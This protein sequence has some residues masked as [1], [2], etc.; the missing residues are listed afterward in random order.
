MLLKRLLCALA[1]TQEEAAGG[2]CPS[3]ARHRPHPVALAPFVRVSGRQ[4]MDC[5]P[6]LC[7][8]RPGRMQNAGV[9]LPGHILRLGYY[10]YTAEKAIRAAQ[11]L[12]RVLNV[13]TAVTRLV[14]APGKEVSRQPSVQSPRASNPLEDAAALKIQGTGL[15]VVQ[16]CARWRWAVRTCAATA[17]S[18]KEGGRWRM[19]GSEG[20]RGAVRASP[21]PHSGPVPCFREFQ[22]E[23]REERAAAEAERD[24]YVVR[25]AAGGRRAEGRMAVTLKNGWQPVDMRLRFGAV[26]SELRRAPER[27][28]LQTHGSTVGI[29]CDCWMAVPPPPPPHT[30]DMVVACPCPRARTVVCCV[31]R[32]ASW[33]DITLSLA[34]D[35]LETIEG[36]GAPDPACRPVRCSLQH[37]T[38]V[39]S[40]PVPQSLGCATP[41]PIASSA[42]PFP[43]PRKTGCQPMAVVVRNTWANPGK[44]GGRSPQAHRPGAWRLPL[45]RSKGRG[46]HVRTFSEKHHRRTVSTLRG[47]AHGR[48]GAGRAFQLDHRRMRVG[49]VPQVPGPWPRVSPLPPWRCPG[50]G[51]CD[52]QSCQ[53]SL[54]GGS[55]FAAADYTGA[56]KPKPPGAVDESTADPLEPA[57]SPLMRQPSLRNARPVDVEEE[58]A[59]LKITGMMPLGPLRAECVC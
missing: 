35:S 5:L 15:C 7:A 48:D 56:K 42:S 58:E 30:H 25:C 39:S 29:A 19:R 4:P 34:L 10:Q 26:A 38:G 36:V 53:G 49:I 3:P 31:P 14:G 2:P 40:A 50:A 46:Y 44:G 28:A 52:R 47:L 57:P 24:S 22:N 37:C 8:S 17:C 18:V 45:C 32:S 13:V 59:A 51:P 54:N 23:R 12:Y 16:S 55:I 21:A 6:G 27:D 1:R 9:E 11:A 20:A 43:G 41:G 33:T